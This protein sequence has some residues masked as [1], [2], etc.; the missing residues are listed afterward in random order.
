MKKAG[1]CTFLSDDTLKIMGYNY[2]NLF[3][4]RNKPCIVYTKTGELQGTLFGEYQNS[5]KYIHPGIIKEIYTL[6][7]GKEIF[8][9][10]FI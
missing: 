10:L 9:E 1:V 7:E 6:K 3:P 5:V 4:E 2:K 8:P